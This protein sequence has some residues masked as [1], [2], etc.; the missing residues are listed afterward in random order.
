MSNP[1]VDDGA[2]VLRHVDDDL[3][4]NVAKFT[5]HRGKRLRHFAK[6]DIR[7]DNLAFNLGRFEFDSI[8]FGLDLPRLGELDAVVDVVSVAAFVL[9]CPLPNG[10][11]AT[12]QRAAFLRP[13]VKRLPAFADFTGE[14]GNISF[15]IC[16]DT[17]SRP[18]CFMFRGL[19]LGRC[20]M[21]SET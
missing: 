16:G 21:S 17:H 12:I 2:A 8:S 5:A 4:R 18:K 11:C 9:L 6:Y 13:C 10:I 1:V 3:V 15:W 20:V 19:L 14:A 7:L